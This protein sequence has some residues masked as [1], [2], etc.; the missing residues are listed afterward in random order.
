MNLWIDQGRKFY[1]KLIQ[2]WLDNKILIYSSYNEGKSIIAEMFI[3]TLKAKIY[4]IVTAN[5]SKS[6]LSYLNKLVD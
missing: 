3:K 2:K 5:D 4:K 6:S 1:N